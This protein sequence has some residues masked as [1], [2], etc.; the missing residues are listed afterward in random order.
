MI[1][2]LAKL[3]VGLSMLI[4]AAFVVAFAAWC[5]FGCKA[6]PYTGDDLGSIE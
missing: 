5:V 2:T 6:D 4:A 1:E 3:T